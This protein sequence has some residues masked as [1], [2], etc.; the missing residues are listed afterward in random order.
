MREEGLV[1]VKEEKKSCFIGCLFRLVTVAVAVYGAVMAVKKVM[2]RLS[3]RLEADNETSERKRFLSF[4]NGRTIS[5]DE[6]PVSGI[7]INTVASGVEL[8]LTEAELSEYTEVCVRTVLGG[9]VVKVPPMVRVEVDDTDVMSGFM[10]LVPQYE[11]EELP[12]I[13]VKVQS[14]LSCVKV[15]MQ[16]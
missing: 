1:V 9:V 13:H 15:E 14:L 11:S 12:V 3:D 7:E 16:A 6:E 4:L 8:D 5:L 10:N 2:T